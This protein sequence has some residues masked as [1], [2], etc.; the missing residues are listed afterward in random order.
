MDH[1][2]E[3]TDETADHGSTAQNL[4]DATASCKNISFIGLKYLSYKSFSIYFLKS[5]IHSRQVYKKKQ[6]GSKQRSTIRMLCNQMK[7][8]LPMH[9][10]SEIL[11]DG[12]QG[13]VLLIFLQKII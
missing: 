12:M 1:T 8:I 5:H 7:M 2:V 10:N 4:T 13:D 11:D 3:N 9:A 6:L